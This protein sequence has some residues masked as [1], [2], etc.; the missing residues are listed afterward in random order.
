[1]EKQ[2]VIT[3]GTN[4]SRTLQGHLQALKSNA[5]EVRHAIKQDYQ[6][7]ISSLRNLHTKSSVR[8][9]LQSKFKKNTTNATTPEN[10]SK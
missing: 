1:M 6:E 9:Y 10:P 8:T 5:S 3:T 7:I 4:Q 2:P